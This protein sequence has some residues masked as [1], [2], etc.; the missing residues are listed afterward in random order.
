MRVVNVHERV[1]DV[2]ADRVGQLIDGLASADDRLWPHDRWPAMR[3]DRPLGVGSSGG[4]GPIGYVSVV[5]PGPPRPIPFH[6]TEEFV[7]THRFEVEPIEA[8]EER[9]CGTRLKCR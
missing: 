6:R 9:G 3:F 5:T 8:R 2:P 1:L 7:G 4:H